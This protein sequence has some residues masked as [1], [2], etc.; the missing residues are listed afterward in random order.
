MVLKGIADTQCGLKVFT[1]EAALAIFPRMSVFGFA[2]DVEML[3]LAMKFGLRIR[4]TP[5]HLTHS[6][7]SKVRLLRD[8]VVMFSDLTRIQQRMKRFDLAGC[9]AA[10]PDMFERTA[11]VRC[12]AER[13]DARLI[14]SRGDRDVLRCGHCGTQYE[15]PRQ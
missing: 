5:V 4:K 11:C 12:G 9:K 7:A 8:S 14:S 13:Y 2:F 15:S 1:R 6:R 3:A 10:P